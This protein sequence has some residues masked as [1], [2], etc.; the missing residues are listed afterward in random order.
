MSEHFLQ[1]WSRRKAE[2][3]ALS[4]PAPVPSS[5]GPAASA[6]TTASPLTETHPVARALPTLG[7]AAA[8]AFDADYTPF[9]V[10]GLDP[11]VHRAA[12]KQLFS[13]PHFNLMDGLDIYM[14]D[15]NRPSPMSAAMLACLTHAG[16]TL[17]PQ[18]VR[19]ATA[20]SVTA[21][22]A[23]EAPI[24]AQHARNQVDHVDIDIDIELGELAEAPFQK[25]ADLP[26]MAAL[27]ADAAGPLPDPV[28]A[29][30]YRSQGRTLIIGAGDTA[31]HWAHQLH[32]QLDVTVLLTD[33]PARLP[34]KRDFIVLAGC[35]VY[36]DGW[37]GAFNARWQPTIG[38]GQSQAGS[39]DLIFDLSA[40]PLIPLHQ[41]PQGYFASG[42]DLRA[43][44][45]DAGELIQLV[46]EFEKPRYFQ[47][48]QRLCAHQRN[49]QTGC[50]ACIDLCS[51]RAIA[52]DGDHVRVNPY[53]CAG[54]GAC[55]TV[56]PSGAI[57]YASPSVPHTGRRCK[58]TL[59]AYAEAGGE[60][61]CLLL[62]DAEHG[63][64]LVQELG[65]QARSRQDL[66][67]MPP[68]VLPLELPHVAATGIDVW[69]GATAYGASTVKILCT[70]AEAPDYRIALKAQ[71][72][73]A[74][75][76][77]DGLGLATLRVSVI[78]ADT[79]AEL[80]AVLQREPTTAGALPAAKFALFDAKRNSL[81]FIL[82]H[83]YAHAPIGKDSID[84]IALPAGAP[85]GALAVDPATCTLCMACTGACPTSALMSSND[86][87]QLRFIEK[88][89]I[90]CGLCVQT[91]P[92]GAI[93]LVPRLSRQATAGTPVTLHRAEA[94]CCIVCDKPIGSVK[95]VEKLLLKL[96]SHDA[97]AGNPERLRMCAD[98][99]VVDMLAP[100]PPA[101]EGVREIHRRQ[102]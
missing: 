20:A 82:A 51:A 89:C 2:S 88:N 55:S 54:C 43:Q 34:A 86:T 95:V 85:F 63:A 3:T 7:D 53:L 33:R 46:G 50:T 98:C 16:S 75:A 56:C 76:I 19:N 28:P 65:R 67:H 29:V 9:M 17:H 49:G 61:A 96:G 37:L 87:P 97:F 71:A 4:A 22:V 94:F 40:A 10:R 14:D 32:P 27:L 47:Y 80:A 102:T 38:G 11:S 81:D 57:R 6:S 52:A 99:R 18:P 15:Y 5:A 70:G 8:L 31:L 36:L 101:S 69:L 59:S 41:P 92:E 24:D 12:M 35:D 100:A 77:L 23:E 60:H 66:A 45:R 48:K 42:A 62:H 73:I 74:Q 68:N 30:H 13:D 83:L 21:P 79:S 93:S 64:R 39:F 1:R 91:C 25:R 72:A 84:C 26:K 90:Q 58:T 78:E 44:I